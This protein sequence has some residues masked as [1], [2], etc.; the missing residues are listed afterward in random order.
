MSEDICK[1]AAIIAPRH[2]ASRELCKADKQIVAVRGVV[3]VH[4]ARTL[5]LLVRQN[6]WTVYHQTHIYLR[7]MDASTTSRMW[8]PSNGS[9]PRIARVTNISPLANAHVVSLQKDIFVAPNESPRA[10]ARRRRLRSLGLN[11][12]LSA[13]NVANTLYVHGCY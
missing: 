2:L 11:G 1:Y 6:E 10:R 13:Y 9:R 5:R 12:T 8:P 7:C 4:F 3:G